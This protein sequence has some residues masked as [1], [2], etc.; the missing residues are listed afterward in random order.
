LSEPA[1]T[2]NGSSLPFKTTL[3]EA[4]A[5]PLWQVKVKVLDPVKS[6]TDSDPEVDLLPDHEPEA[7]QEV[8]L[9][10][11]QVKVAFLSQV[12]EPLERKSTVGVL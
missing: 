12:T 7:L 2:S 1:L 5:L 6:P 4:L 11:V 9:V 10:D 3:S 8:A